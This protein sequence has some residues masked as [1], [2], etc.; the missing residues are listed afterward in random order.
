MTENDAEFVSALKLKIVEDNLG[1]MTF[2]D[3]SKLKKELNRKIEA[4]AIAYLISATIEA[5]EQSKSKGD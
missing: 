2:D 5:L 3:L 1:D 4:K